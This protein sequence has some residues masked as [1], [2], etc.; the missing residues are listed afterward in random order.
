MDKMMGS[1]IKEDTEGEPS[2]A[3]TETGKGGLFSQGYLRDAPAREY[4]GEGE[5]A[6]FVLTDDETGV[7]RASDGESST[8]PPGKGYRAITVVTDRRVIVLVGDAEDGG[9]KRVTLPL[10]ETTAARADG[11]VLVLEMSS[12]VTW[13]CHADD[14]GVG[15]V[16][17]YV[18]AAATTWRDVEATLDEVKRAIVAAT[19]RRDEGEYDEALDA[20]RDARDDIEAVQERTVEFGAEWPSDA[21][22]DRVEQVRDRCLATAADIRVGY[23]RTKHD[24]GESH[25][26]EGEY[27]RARDAFEEARDAYE[28]VRSLSARHRREIDDVDRA[29]ER[30]EHSIERLDDAPLRNAI[31]ADRRARETEPSL[32]ALDALA[33]ARERYEIVLELDPDAEQRRFAG[34]RDRIREQREDVTDRF[35]ETALSVGTSALEAGEWYSETGKPDLAEAELERAVTALERGL[36]IASTERP[37]EAEELRQ[38]HSTASDR[39]AA[40][41][42]SPTTDGESDSK[43]RSEPSPD[44]ADTVADAAAADTAATDGGLAQRTTAPP[45]SAPEEGAQPVDAPAAAVE[46]ELRNLSPGEFDRVVTT[47]V[48]AMGWRPEATASTACDYLARRP[49]GSGGNLAIRAFPNEDGDRIDPETVRE[50]GR[51]AASV[52]SVEDVMIVT[53]R[54]L[55]D[56][57]TAA[58]NS[59]DV[60]VLDVEYLAATLG[61]PTAIDARSVVPDV[62]N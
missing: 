17:D 50:C 41:R 16:A 34:D 56:A 24:E 8:I 10:V 59:Q 51:L 39:L 35:V 26:R 52:P 44:D 21:M 54:P 27:E 62:E 18:A 33:E 14:S 30:L 5:T 2:A 40:L 37:G 31:D 43:R 29:L 7:E 53:T 20:M 1:I 48:E 55:S 15:E 12:G 13:R 57:A 61:D 46:E 58:A 32:E 60:R 3:L 47:V 9:D 23:A 19:A 36:S 4:V 22:A 45:P 42:E 11:D 25:W 49:D 28:A 6:V 38:E